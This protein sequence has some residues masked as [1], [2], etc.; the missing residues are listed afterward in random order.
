MKEINSHCTSCKYC[1]IEKNGDDVTMSCSEGIESQFMSEYGCYCYEEAD[2]YES[3]Y[4]VEIEGQWIPVSDRLPEPFTAVI[5]AF[6]NG[7]VE[8]IG[9]QNWAEDDSNLIYTDNNDWD[10]ETHV[11]HWMP[12]PKAPGENNAL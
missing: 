10:L 7:D 9:W 3:I 4:G 5:A 11:T 2:S 6:D 8:S 1:L 12:L